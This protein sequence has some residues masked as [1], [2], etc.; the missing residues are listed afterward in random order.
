MNVR[1]VLVQGVV[2][3]GDDGQDVVMPRDELR[4]RV[5]VARL[6]SP[7]AEISVLQMSGG[8]LQ[9]VA[10][11]LSRREAGPAM[12][13]IR[14]R[15]RAAV[16][17]HRAVERAHEL[18]VVHVDVARQRVL[19]LENPRAAKTAPLV[20]RRVRPALILRRAPNRFRRGVRAQATCL[21]EGNPC[22]VAK[23]RLRGQIPLVGIKSPFRGNVWRSAGALGTLGGYECIDQQCRSK[24]KRRSRGS[25]GL[26]HVSTRLANTPRIARARG[27]LHLAEQGVGVHFGAFGSF[28]KSDVVR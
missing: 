10:D 14:R 9:R 4:H 15:V 3:D 6:R 25:I 11:P 7:A 28:R 20:R 16:H 17:E 19:L 27:A 26:I 12:R 23:R 22:V 5:H 2:N 8:D 21:V 24:Q 13:R 18:D 1:L